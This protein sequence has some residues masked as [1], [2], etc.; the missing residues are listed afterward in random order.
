MVIIHP[1]RKGNYILLPEREFSTL[2]YEISRIKPVELIEDQTE[3]YETE[4]DR[5]AYAEAIRDLECG[6]VS[7]FDKLKSAWLKGQSADV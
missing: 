4:E 3:V 2:I 7:D 6:N 5:Q 1:I